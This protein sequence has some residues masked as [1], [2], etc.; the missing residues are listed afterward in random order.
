LARV[1]ETRGLMETLA[2]EALAATVKDMA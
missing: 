1:A 2:M